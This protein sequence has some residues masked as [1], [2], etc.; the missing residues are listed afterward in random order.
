MFYLCLM[1]VCQAAA[2]LGFLISAQ[3]DNVMS[4][5]A[6]AVAYIMPSLCYGGFVVN[7]NTLPVWQAWLQWTSPLR[8]G[9]EGLCIA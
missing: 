4:S 1:L 7:V 8:F 5:T 9:L 2:S 3:S 6:V